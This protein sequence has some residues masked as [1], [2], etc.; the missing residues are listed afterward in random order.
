MITH[1]LYN[2]VTFP[3]DGPDLTNI[4]KIDHGAMP[5][6][7]H[8]MSRGLQVDLSHFAR[9]E[10]ELEQDMERVTA[11]VHSL[12]GVWCN[13]DSGDQVSTLLFKTLGLK[14]AKVKF[15]KSGDRESVENEV[16]VAIQHEHEVV[17]K[18]LDF[19]E[20]SKLLG[21]YVRPMPKLAKRTKHGVWRIYPNLGMTRVPSGRYNCKEPNLL[22]FPTRTARGKQIRFGFITDPGWVY[23]AVDFS[24]F[25]VR[26][27]AHSSRDPNLMAI[28]FNEEDIYSDF[29]IAA[30]QIPDRRY[31]D[32]SGKWKYPGVDKETQ[33]FPSKT[34][35]LASIYD[36]TAMGLQ[37]QM[38]VV[39]RNCRKPTSSDKKDTP[40]HDCRDFAPLWTEDACQVL[41]KAFYLRYPGLLT[42]RRRHHARARQCG[43][44]WDEWGRLHHVAAVHSVHPWV[45]SGALRE[46]GNFPYQGLN[47]GALKLS[48]AKLHD[49]FQGTGMLEEVVHPLLPIHDELLFECRE[50]MAEDIGEHVRETF[51]GIVP[52]NVPVKAEWSSGPDWGSAK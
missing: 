24:Q 6:T 1:R 25:E 21:T 42:D 5:M 27:A 38:P 4:E 9:M 44:I 49:D 11:E 32:E 13:L 15:T 35:T 39:C 36:V 40:L 41:I 14:Q 50:D 51:E 46:V 43:F 8:M 37:E 52:L 18:I 20:F 16:L 7:L 31:K 17:P 28:Y 29:A 22:A 12:T 45:V 10:K 3:C 33:R 48:M 23:V 2:G 19:K 47:S 34:C 30:F 26:A